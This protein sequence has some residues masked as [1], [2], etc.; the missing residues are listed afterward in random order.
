MNTPTTGLDFTSR[1]IFTSL[2][3]K[4][5]E[6]QYSGWRETTAKFILWYYQSSVVIIPDFLPGLGFIDHYIL[7]Q[8]SLWILKAN[9]DQVSTEEIGFLDEACKKLASTPPTP[10]TKEVAPAEPAGK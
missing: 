6:G 7:A 4:V 3:K 1:R 10:K 8:F 9:P 2:L 5:L